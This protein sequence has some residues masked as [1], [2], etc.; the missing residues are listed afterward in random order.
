MAPAIAKKTG[1][2]ALETPAENRKHRRERIEGG[3]KRERERKRGREEG[4]KKERKKRK[5]VKYQSEDRWKVLSV[6]DWLL[7]SL[8]LIILFLFI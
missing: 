2:L 8:Y 7:S 5:V 3:R 1:L 6:M 4:R